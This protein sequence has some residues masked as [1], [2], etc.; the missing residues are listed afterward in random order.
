MTLE[1]ENSGIPEYPLI[2]GFPTCGTR[3]T[4]GTRK[5]SRWYA[6]GFPKEQE[7]MVAFQKIITQKNIVIWI[8]LHVFAYL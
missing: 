1:N 2:Q 4:S 7:K 3:T 5:L 8:W 6:R